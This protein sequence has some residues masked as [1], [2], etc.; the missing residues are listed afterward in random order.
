MCR[1]VSVLLF[2]FTLSGVV[3]AD[4]TDGLFASF[5]TSMGSFTCRLDY[6][7]APMTCANFISLAEI[8]E[9]P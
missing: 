7:E 2:L 6:A 5:N 8:E 3:F 1:I 4:L 9:N